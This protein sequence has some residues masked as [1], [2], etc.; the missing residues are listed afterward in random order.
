MY[1]FTL[2]KPKDSKKSNHWKRQR[3]LSAVILHDGNN[4]LAM[5]TFEPTRNSM[6][7]CYGWKLMSR[8][9]EVLK[10]MLE[11]ICIIYPPQRDIEVKI[12]EC[13]KLP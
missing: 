4:Y 12:V 11:D 7:D 1:Y 13:K 3:M 9:K 2:E 10:E 6:I 5:A 8:T